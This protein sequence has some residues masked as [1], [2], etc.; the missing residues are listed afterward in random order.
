[1]NEPIQHPPWCDHRHVADWPMH[2]AVVGKVPVAASLAFNIDLQ[3]WTGEPVRVAL[4]SEGD[5]IDMSFELLPEFARLLG[6]A[7]IQAADVADGV[8]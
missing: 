1:M 5:G 7:L 4:T 8:R 3:Q 2:T 6:L